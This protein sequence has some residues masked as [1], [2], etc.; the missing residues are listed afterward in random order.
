MRLKKPS[1]VAALFIGLFAGT[2]NAQN[3]IEAKI[4]FAFFVRGEQ[5]PAGR[6]R[7]T[8]S[9]ALLAI[10]GRDNDAHM[11]VIASPAGGRDPKGDEPVLVFNRFEKT[12]R[13]TEVW[14]SETQGASLV[15]Y[16]HHKA[17]PP[18]ASATG[19]VLITA[20]ATELW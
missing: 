16:R 11:F 17:A 9:Q 18:A 7:I 14:N 19:R 6:Y 15:P 13:L 10:H 12:Y 8:N 5:F 1:V 20:A 4:P 2:S 3:V